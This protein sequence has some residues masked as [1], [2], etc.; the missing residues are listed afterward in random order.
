MDL[1]LQVVHATSL[2]KINLLVYG[3]KAM[4]KADSSLNH[5]DVHTGH[6]TSVYGFNGN[7]INYSSSLMDTSSEGCDVWE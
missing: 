7:V 3:E 6:L 5:T 1:L 4:I 2:G